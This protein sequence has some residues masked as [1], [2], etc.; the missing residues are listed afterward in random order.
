LGTT[1]ILHALDLPNVTLKVNPMRVGGFD[2]AVI[3]SHYALGLEDFQATYTTL[4]GLASIRLRPF[5]TVHLGAANVWLTAD[6]M[7][8][9]STMAPILSTLTGQELNEYALEQAE[10]VDLNIDA[11]L[12]TFRFATDL[13]LNRRDSLVLQAS[14]T[15]GGDFKSA[16]PLPPGFELPPILGIDAALEAPQRI[17]DTMTMSLAWQMAW[18]HTELR[19]GLGYST[20]PGSWLLQSTEFAYRFGGKT[21]RSEYRM[22]RTWRQN[23]AEIGVPQNLAPTQGEVEAARSKMAS[24]GAEPVGVLAPVPTATTEVSEQQA[25]SAKTVVEQTDDQRAAGDEE[26]ALREEEAALLEE[27]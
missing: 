15:I 20:S 25:G 27:E 18:K 5:W 6:G 23:R 13:R 22:R 1:P 11:Q 14:T 16:D 8:D 7:P 21:R 2:M 9:L 17:D 4:G 10:N 12:R 24:E 3:V 26:A 19:L